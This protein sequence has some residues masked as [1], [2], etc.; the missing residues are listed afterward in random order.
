LC[1][2]NK[3]NIMISFKLP[4]I[5]SQV[6]PVAAAAKIWNALFDNVV[7]AVDSFWHQLKTFFQFQ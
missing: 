1:R 2:A 5:G 7:S 6:F 3:A 4:T